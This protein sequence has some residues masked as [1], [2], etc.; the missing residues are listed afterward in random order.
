M[1]PFIVLTV[2]LFLFRALGAAGVEALSSWPAATRAALAVMLLLTASA[3]FTPM[4]EDL[5]RMMPPS[6]PYPR[7]VVFLTGIFELLGAAGLLVPPVQR[8]AGMALV[9]FLIAVLPANVHAA[10]AGVTLRGK[11]PTPLWLRVPLQ[12]LFIG[13][14]WWSTQATG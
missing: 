1:A 10:R 2:S 6:V 5:V 12:L 13:L 7:Q 8:V 4:K 9:L 3:H 11:P 14:T